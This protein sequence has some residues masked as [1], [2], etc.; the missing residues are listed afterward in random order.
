MKAAKRSYIG[1]PVQHALG[2]IGGK[3]QIGIIWNLRK[4]A[5]RFGELRRRL[6]GLSEKVLAGNLRFFEQNGIVG[7]TIFAE[8]PPRVEYRLT[9]E[10]ARLVPALEAVVKW[11]H[12]HLQ[13]QTVNPGMRLTPL[14]TIAE[15]ATL[16]S[17][18]R[19]RAL[20]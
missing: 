2:F 11:G 10:G 15:I 12:A 19:D 16:R 20:R 4:K 1:C 6:P 18:A 5:L 14:E 3:W 8:V 9:P 7:K 17:P 13:K